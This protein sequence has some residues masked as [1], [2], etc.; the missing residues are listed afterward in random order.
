MRGFA[1]LIELII[2]FF[3]FIFKKLGFNAVLLILLVIELIGMSFY[4]TSNYRNYIYE[5]NSRL[6]RVTELTQLEASEIPDVY[7]DSLSDSDSY[8]LVNVQIGN[9][10][11]NEAFYPTLHI[12]NQEAKTFTTR[13]LDYYDALKEYHDFY[14]DSVIPPGTVV[15][16]PYLV[17]VPE[18]ALNTTTELV[19]Y[20]SYLNADRKSENQLEKKQ[21][22][23]RTPF[24]DNK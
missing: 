18:Y 23:L 12:R 13:R 9:Y 20:Y 19:I 22:I 15:Q 10:Y 24:S 2:N 14:P 21:H 8:Y 1:L 7:K 17:S 6:E 3:A 16:A 4:F 11:L 5:D